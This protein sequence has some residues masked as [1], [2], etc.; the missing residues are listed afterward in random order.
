MMPPCPPDCLICR[1][2]K[3]HGDALIAVAV[4]AVLALFVLFR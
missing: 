3:K 1:Y 4:L 2:E